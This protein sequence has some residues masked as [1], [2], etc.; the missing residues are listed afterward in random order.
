MEKKV[1]VLDLLE[2]ESSK[3]IAK[4][5]PQIQGGI[6]KNIDSINRKAKEIGEA[7]TVAMV[8]FSNRVKEFNQDAVAFDSYLQDLL[9]GDL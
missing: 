3:L 1:D 6:E 4:K 7:E 5:T 9:E 8:A 2:E